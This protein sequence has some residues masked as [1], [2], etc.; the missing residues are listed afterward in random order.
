MDARIKSLFKKIES[1][2]DEE[3]LVKYLESAESDVSRLIC[4]I[5]EDNNVRADQ[6][7]KGNVE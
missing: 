2:S 3:F 5:E 6:K 4:N 1:L 7:D